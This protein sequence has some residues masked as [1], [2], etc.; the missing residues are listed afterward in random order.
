MNQLK[1]LK[2]LSINYPTIAQASEE[3]INLSAILN[4]P[5][6]TE[7]FISDLHGEYEQVLHV[8]KNGSGSIRQKIDEVFAPD[9][10]TERERRQLAT[11]IYYPEQKLDQIKMT[12]SD[13][14]C[15]YQITLRRLIQVARRASSKYTRSKVRKSLPREFSYVI[16][17]LL[18]ER[19]DMYDKEAYYNEIIQTIIRTDRAKEC[20]TAFCNLIQRLAIDRLHVIGDIF[21]R[22]PGAHIVMDRLIQYKSIDFQWGNHDVA[23]MGAASGHL[24]CIANVIRLSA[25]YGNL[26]TLEEGY[27]INLI[28]LAKFALDTYRDDPCT[29]F[30]V[31]Y[32]NH[33]YDLLDLELDK[34]MHKAISVIQFKL[35]GQLIKKHPEFKMENRLLLDKINFQECTVTID[36]TVYPL[37][38]C[39]FPTIDP[40]DPYALSDDEA[41]V[42]ERIRTAF[43]NCQK[44]QT[45]V[46]FIFSH[47]SLYLCYNSNLLYH[48]CIPFNRDGSFRKANIAGKEYSGKSLYDILENYARKGFYLRCGPEKEYGQDILWY[49]WSSE[50]SP[51]FGKEKMATFERYFVHDKE[52]QSEL[53][54]CYYQ[55]I[56]QDEIVDRIFEE[57]HMDKTTSHIINGHIPVDL[58]HGDSPIHCNGRVLI[59]DGGFSK[60]YHKQTGIAGYTLVYNSYGMRLVSHE[61]FESQESAITNETD[62]Y[63]EQV[64]VEKARDRMIV[65]DTDNGKQMKERIADLEALLEAYR[66]G[67]IRE[68]Y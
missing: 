6:G 46:R 38:D 31:Q 64:L 16:E 32:S 48:G 3:I 40:L 19:D 25:R 7:H 61:A 33:S 52:L 29:C 36:G 30:D 41:L 26:S 47:G 27:G 50:C 43:L 4:L 57:F 62:I 1:Y 39:H 21:D 10:M 18:H 14:N 8:L 12:G 35:E 13:L 37:E 66:S 11:L 67:L 17:E 49:L 56:D 53:K 65:A 24:A 45:H 58:K 9:A 63:S 59:I 60:P 5:K 44:L 68:R 20:I 34:K 28:P 55:F 42:M 23:W 15:W 22:G 51:L 2:Q 54:N